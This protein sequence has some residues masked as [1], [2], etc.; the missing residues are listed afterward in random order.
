MYN[1]GFDLTTDTVTTNSA[2]DFWNNLATASAG[3]V[4]LFVILAFIALGIAIFLI[5]SECKMFKKAGEAWWKA[6]IPV[7]STW[8][9]A[10]I[11]GLAWWWCPIMIG[12]SA[13]ATFKNI[14]YVGGFAALVISFN[15]FYNLS[16]KFGKSNGFAFLCTVLPIIG[17]PILAFG[18][19]KYNASA[20][21]DKNGIF[22]VE[23]NI[24]K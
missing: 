11:A 4:V 21:T 15:F 6:L 18:S 2:T 5:I 7:Y 8:I 1:G 19:D 23:N 24:A 10:K 13:L 3:L 16:K 20:K 14:T 17:I 12:V 9:E 22:A